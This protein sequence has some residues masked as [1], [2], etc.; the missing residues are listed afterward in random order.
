MLS[1]KLKL[2]MTK[3]KIII[4]SPSRLKQQVLHDFG[5]FVFEDIEIA[6]SSEVR[7]L[8]V[9]FGD[10]LTFR[11]HINDVVRNVNFALLNLKSVK[12]YLPHDLF[13]DL[14]ISEVLSLERVIRVI[15]E[16]YLPRLL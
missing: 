6:P 9:I 15:S 1:R 10:E 7:N 16:S 2:N 3:F 12:I 5:S 4:F 13:I 8:G 14:I 11:Q